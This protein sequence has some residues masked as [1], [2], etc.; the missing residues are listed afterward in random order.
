MQI[1]KDKKITQE[2]VNVIH[3]YT[4]LWLKSKTLPYLWW[5]TACNIKCRFPLDFTGEEPNFVFLALRIIYRKEGSLATFTRMLSMSVCLGIAGRFTFFTADTAQ[6]GA[7]AMLASSGLSLGVFVH[8]RREQ[9][10]S[11]WSPIP[12]AA[13]LFLQAYHR[14]CLQGGWNPVQTLSKILV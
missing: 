9:S 6:V 3:F 2:L 11:C 13:S 1:R 14:P 10:H 4:V 12:F 8:Q 7:P 5:A